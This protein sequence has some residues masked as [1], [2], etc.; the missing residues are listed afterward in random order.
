MPRLSLPAV[1]LNEAR[2]THLIDLILELF[3][4]GE[5]KEIGTKQSTIEGILLISSTSPCP[6]LR[7]VYLHKAL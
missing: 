6:R 3:T 1:G 4:F 7:Y 2:L 5:L